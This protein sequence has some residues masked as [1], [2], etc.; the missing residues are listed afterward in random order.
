MRHLVLLTISLLA[1]N[2]ACAS[3]KLSS[4]PS[5]ITEA[6]TNG[7]VDRT[8]LI[9]ELERAITQHSGTDKSLLRLW[10]A[11]Q[12]RLSNKNNEARVE[13]ESILKAA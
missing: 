12:L 4:A 3:S 5:V 9:A 7:S 2:A 1:M 10:L 6:Y 13:F 11:E 8:V